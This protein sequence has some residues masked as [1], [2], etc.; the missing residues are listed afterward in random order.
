MHTQGESRAK[1]KAEIG[2]MW[3]ELRNV[4]DCHE[5]PEA[6]GE[7]RDRFSLTSPRGRP[8]LGLLALRNE[9]LPH[10]WDPQPSPTNPHQS[11]KPTQNHKGATEHITGQFK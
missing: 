3:Q 4:E 1:M 2:V 6:T 10:L 7:A 8:H 5:P 11:T 9:K